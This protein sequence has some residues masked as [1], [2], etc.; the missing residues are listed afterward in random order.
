MRTLLLSDNLCEI[1]FVFFYQDLTD[2]QDHL[3]HEVNPVCK[4]LVDH[5]ENLDLRAHL[6]LQEHPATEENGANKD[7]RVHRDQL[8]PLDREENLDRG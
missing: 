7:L 1:V 3:D 8:D 2:N 5:G 6:E 4:D